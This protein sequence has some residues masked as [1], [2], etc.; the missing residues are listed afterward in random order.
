MNYY[1][2]IDPGVHGAFTVIDDKNKVKDQFV[3]PLIDGKIDLQELRNL[4]ALT[5]IAYPGLES[6]LEE[7]GVLFGVSKSSMATMFRALGNKEGILTGLGLSHILASPKTW[8]KLI[9][10]D[11]DI[12]K[13]KSKT[14]KKLVNDTKAT[15]FNAAKRL[16]PNHD[17]WYYGNNEDNK[18][19]RTKVNDGLVDSLLIAKYCQIINK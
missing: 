18:G 6:V 16:F 7:P 4:L 9:W 19:R 17:N 13:K 1:L 11:T 10:I 2:G 3:V 5:E 14:G 15:S 8:Q 12:V